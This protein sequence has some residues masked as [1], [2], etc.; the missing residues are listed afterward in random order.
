MKQ[1]YHQSWHLLF[2]LSDRSP[3]ELLLLF[4]YY[5]TKAAQENTNIQTYKTYK[6]ASEVSRCNIVTQISSRRLVRYRWVLL[7]GISLLCWSFH[8]SLESGVAAS[9]SQVKSI[10][11]PIGFQMLE[12]R[13]RIIRVALL[14]STDTD[15]R[16]QPG[17]FYSQNILYLTFGF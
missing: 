12:P 16:T 4:I 11:L 7:S 5:A 15:T 1:C 10:M 8:S 6:K 2:Q 9:S 17:Y 14:S 13:G 3:G